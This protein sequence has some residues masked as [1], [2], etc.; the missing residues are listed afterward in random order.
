[1]DHVYASSFV[2]SWVGAWSTSEV[3]RI[4]SHFADDPQF[5]SPIAARQLA[6]TGDVLGG[7]DGLRFNWHLGLDRIPDF[8]F[9]GREIFIGVDGVR[10]KNQTG[11]QGGEALRGDVVARC[12]ATYAENDAIAVS[13]VR[14]QGA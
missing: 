9:T 3:D 2:D 14:S 8:H 7:K 13:G 11:A 1:M 6:D 10:Q 5:T 12:E 4:L